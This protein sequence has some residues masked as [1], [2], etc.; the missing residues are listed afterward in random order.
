MAF[1][2]RFWRMKRGKRRSGLDES[3]HLP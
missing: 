2:G 3:E 1:W